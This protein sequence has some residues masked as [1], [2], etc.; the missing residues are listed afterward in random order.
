MKT[1][2]ATSPAPK[3]R[4]D[5]RQPDYWID[6][7]GLDFDLR[8]G[9][10][11]VTARLSMRRNGE[12]DRPLVLDGEELETLLVQVDGD[13]REAGSGYSIDG[14]QLTLGNLPAEFVLTTE[15]QIKP[16]TNTAL[17]G[18]YKTS[19]NYCTQCE[20]EGFRRITWF[21]DRPDVMAVYEVSISA[22]TAT[23]PVMLSN[24]NKVSEESLPSGRHKVVWRDPFKKPSYLFA[25]VA[26]DLHCHA[27]TFRTMS[28]RD[29]R[30]EIWVEP[31]NKDACEHALQSLM[32]SMTWDEEAFGREYDL[33]VY[34]IV[35]VNDFNMGA[36]EN[37]GLNVFNSK[38]VLAK[39]DTATDSDYEAIESVIGHE[40]FHNWTGNRITCRD[41]FQLTLKEGLTVYRDQEFTA[42]RTS[43]AV[44]RIDDVGGLRSAQFM[45]DA[46]P[47][48]HP[49]RPESYIEMDN[50]YTST[51]YQKGAEVIR[52]YQTL[53]GVD[54][55]RKGTDLY[56]ERH[57]GQAVA[58]DDFRDAMASSAGRDLEQF[59]NWYLQ[60]G[61]PI[62]RVES[63]Y[64]A[65]SQSFELIFRQEAPSGQDAGRFRPMHMPIRMGL[66]GPD[67]A[68][69]ALHVEGEAGGGELERVIELLQLETRVRF[70]HVAAEPVASLL[71]AFS[72]PVVMRYERPQSD[73]VHLMAHDTDAFTR[74]DSAQTLY[75][76]AVLKLA[77]DAGGESDWALDGALVEA[78]RAVLT[79]EHLD[80]STRAL[81]LTLPG[82]RVLSQ[83]MDV[84]DPDALYAARTFVRQSL[85]R[86]CSAE[87]DGI[88]N[89]TKASGAY[90]A[91]KGEIDRRRLHGTALFYLAAADEARG[92]VLAAAELAAADNMTDTMAALACLVGLDV[93]QR[94]VALADFYSRWSQDPLVLDKWFTQQACSRLP[95][96]AQRVLDLAGHADFSLGNPNRA[97]ALVG[98]FSQANPTG[99]HQR[100]GMGYRFLAD[101]VIAL[102]ATN[103]QIAARFVGGFNSWKRY[104][105]ARQ[106]LMRA[107]LTRIQSQEG[108]SKNTSEI[109]SRALS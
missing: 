15:V 92:S 89:T 32:H 90:V 80:G 31:R 100:D 99:F 30:C 28:G 85:A 21:L 12:H 95:G 49:I 5:Y 97:R 52:M 84:I 38:Y 35:A 75:G 16:E 9:C 106:A 76:D 63:S 87:L 45:E 43:P 17:S 71:R 44:K 13:V 69:I 37:K 10:S 81:M 47:M 108:L 18:L 25:L 41:W 83:A 94:A 91:D 51:V 86:A 48:A 55:F 56:F 70:T 57:D 72:A 53:L 74:W 103:P 20:A 11:S 8:D 105:A 24:G 3:Y 58:C 102:D 50:F 66:L 14:E 7:V 79:D 64:D 54:G 4:K 60:A 23:C 62:L 82:E 40:Y 33:D 109:V 67:G 96:A 59:E 26:G 42:S 73:L 101:Q 93:P 2:V 88:Y 36:M 39:P 104:D 29:V 98:A 19:G 61:T 65:A 27:G 107:E 77:L 46:G 78:F 68:P 22:D 34:M 6:T 1:D